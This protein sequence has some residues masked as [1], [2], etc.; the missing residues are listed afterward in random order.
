MV[1]TKN[2][3]AMET[4]DKTLSTFCHPMALANINPSEETE[5][6]IYIPTLNNE[7]ARAL[8]F[9]G[10]VSEIMLKQSGNAALYVIYN[11]ILGIRI[12]VK[13]FA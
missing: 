13:L 5:S 6:P 7:L 9:G 12:A 4:A 8:Y 2:E 10:N 3:Q 11:A 1:R